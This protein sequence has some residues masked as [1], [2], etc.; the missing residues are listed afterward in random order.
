METDA[1]VERDLRTMIAKARRAGI[2]GPFVF[3]GVPERYRVLSD[4]IAEEDE[5][6]AR[7]ARE[8]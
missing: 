7:I 5:R 6:A 4:R 1:N 2:R 3:V 8:P